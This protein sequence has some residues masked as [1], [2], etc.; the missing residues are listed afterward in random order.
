MKVT[1]YVEKQPG[2]RNCSC[3]IDE[4]FDKCGLIGYGPTVDAAIEDLKTSREEC[5]ENGHKIPELEMTFKYDLWA[6][7]D[8]FPV[9]ATLV[10]K[11]IGINP[12]LMR[13]YISGN[14]KPSL[15]R[16]EEIQEG[17]RQ[18]GNRLSTVSLVRF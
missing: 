1:V 8:K 4:T 13:Q 16:I 17:I 15:K 14:K 6:F 10:A 11:E 12:S 9:N 5:I 18:L 3:Y 2:V 7:F